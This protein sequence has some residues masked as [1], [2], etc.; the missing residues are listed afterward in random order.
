LITHDKNRHYPKRITHEKRLVR[1][2]RKLARKSTKAVRAADRGIG[3]EII[4]GLIEAIA[5][6]RGEDTG[7]VFKAAP[8]SARKATVS[9]APNFSPAEI[10]SIRKTLGLS[11]AV[12]AQ[13]LN[14]SAETAK[15][16]EQ[17]KAPPSGPS[18]RLLEIA[19]D[20]PRVIVERVVAIGGRRKQAASG[21]ES[22]VSE[23]RSGLDRRISIARK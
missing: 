15:A 11:Q 5:F 6:E 23:R 17:G 2:M 14:V 19:R 20:H 9:P 21:S 18:K 13:A 10:A 1:T 7:A 12:F 4:A 22:R 3:A 8:I 16:W